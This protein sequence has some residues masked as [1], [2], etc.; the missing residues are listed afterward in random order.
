MSMTRYK[1]SRMS[2]TE[3][4]VLHLLREVDDPGSPHL[5]EEQDEVLDWLRLVMT[6]AKG[7]GFDV[8]PYDADYVSADE[9]KLLGWLALYQRERLEYDVV[10]DSALIRAM[11]YAADA[12]KMAG[13][14]LPFQAV[15]RAGFVS[16]PEIVSLPAVAPTPE[17]IER[18]VHAR[19]RARH[20][21]DAH[22]AR[23]RV[24]AY[25][26]THGAAPAAELCA[27][28]VS[29]Q[30]LSVLRAQGV[31]VRPRY[32]VYALPSI[33]E[34]DAEASEPPIKLEQ[35]EGEPSPSF[36]RLRYRIVPGPFASPV[37]MASAGTEPSPALAG[38]SAR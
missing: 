2:R 16:D 28:R 10:A 29:R 6:R 11:R 27:L 4:R 21:N 1:A 33:V 23:A 37:G 20:G 38:L 9:L 14:R 22:T 30:Y 15:L 18:A 7:L 34:T 25:L 19:L 31:I 12:L 8:R 17:I 13:C 24:I 36:R 32:G 3:R 26:R 35:N 5:S